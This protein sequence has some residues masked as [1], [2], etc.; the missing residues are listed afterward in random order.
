MNRRIKTTVGL[1]ADPSFDGIDEL[2]GV[3]TKLKAARE[4][5]L[6]KIEKQDAKPKPQFTKKEMRE[7]A[8]A[9]FAKLDELADKVD[10]DLTDRQMVEA[11]VQ[12]IEID[13]DAKTGV[14]F[15]IRRSS[16]SIGVHTGRRR[17]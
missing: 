16:G 1:L 2:A 9:Q 17:G 5:L 3:L 13:P 7:W 15:P 12:K 10:V 6:K 8:K 14:V 11:F 4:K